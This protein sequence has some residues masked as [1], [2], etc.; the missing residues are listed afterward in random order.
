M[1]PQSIHTAIINHY[2][3]KKTEAIAM[4]EL[5]YNKSVAIGEHT[6]ILDE[7]KKWVEI[8]EKSESCIESLNRILREGQSKKNE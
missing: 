8:L 3:A 6:S 5:I 4:L 7:A 2:L 1:T